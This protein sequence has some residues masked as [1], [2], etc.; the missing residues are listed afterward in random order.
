MLVA[1][2]L[3]FAVS[4]QLFGVRAGIITMLAFSGLGY[5]L[6]LSTILRGYMLVLTLFLLALWLTL[7]YFER[8]SVWLGIGVGLTLTVMFYIHNLALISIPILVLFSLILFRAPRRW[9]TLWL[10][11]GVIVAALCLPYLFSRLYI[12]D[13]KATISEQFIPEV[14]PDVRL[15]NHYLDY[16]GQQPALFAA[17]FVIATA[18]IVDRWRLGRHTVALILWM[19]MPVALIG[20]VSSFDAF[21]AR[22]LSWVMVGVAL[23]IGWGL[24]L[25][26]RAAMIAAALV[27]ALVNF[28]RIPLNERYET[29]PRLPFVTAFTELRQQLRNG[30]VILTDL[31]CRD[32]IPIDAEEWDYAVRAHF[33]NGLT[34]ISSAQLEANPTTYRRVWYVA[35]KGKETPQTLAA[36]EQFRG[37]ISHIGPDNFLFRLYE[38]PVDPVGVLFENGMRLHGA[39]LLNDANLS[40]VWREG[41]TVKLRL[42]WSVDQPVQ[43]DYSEGSYLWDRQKG[44]IAQRDDP[45]LVL[46]GPTATSQWLPGQL[47]IEERTLKLAYPLTTGDYDIMLSLYQ[48]WDGVRIPAPGVTADTLLKLGAI[49]VKAW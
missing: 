18:L 4:R 45:P 1:A 7:C 39:E 42:F 37:L 20:V 29:I 32:C 12:I 21:N 6:F 26:P 22:H 48:W 33:P 44:V 16:L 40:L 34:F 24:A 14:A 23:W 2:A 43:F 9:F 25:L 13:V 17:L 30:D 19:L 28:D 11:P 36:V 38:A 35:T 31:I 27:L 47:Y 8:P 46:N 49:Y 3:L 10:L 41:D 15:V 5:V